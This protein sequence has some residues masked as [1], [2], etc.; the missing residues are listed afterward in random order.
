[1]NIRK[2][3]ATDKQ[4]VLKISERL[5]D[6]ETPTWRTSEEIASEDI[7]TLDNYFSYP[8]PKQH[9]YVAEQET[10]VVGI[11]FLE[12]RTDFFNKS[13]LLHI[14]ILAVDKD[15]SG[16]GIGSKLLGYSESFAQELDIR[17]ISLNV[18]SSNQH[19]RDIYKN[20]GFNE[21][22]IFMLKDV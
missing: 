20:K 18:F 4:S 1:M 8:K 22:T 10:T 17:R 16:Y 7:K 5:S 9:L 11:L 19:A 14:S 21:E 2:A 6:F 13:R 3:L 15:H 12:E